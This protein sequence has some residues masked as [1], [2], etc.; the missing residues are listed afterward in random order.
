MKNRVHYLLRLLLGIRPAESF[1]DGIRRKILKVQKR[2]PH[3]QFSET[4][5]VNHLRSLGINTGDVVIVHASWRGM[6]ALES[7]PASVVEILLKTIGKTGTLVMPC[8]GSKSEKLDVK[9]TKS[10]AG[11]LSETL[12]N[13]DGAI[14]SAFPKFSMVAYGANA[15]AIISSHVNSTYQFDELSPYYISM[16]KYNAKV[17][18]IGMGEKTHKISVF[19]CASYKCKDKTDFYNNCFTKKCSGE[20]IIENEAVQFE[21]IDRADNYSNNKKVFLSLF[22]SV[23]KHIINHKGYSI[24]MFKAADAYRIAYNFCI[25]GG[26]LYTH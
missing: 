4:S 21:Y 10:T 26:E 11:V 14:R 8:Y 12:R 19:H 17:L 16:D 18:L 3:K 23:P 9:K 24:V 1:D 22:G 5:F 2:L 25:N 15:E 7:T 6:Y 20:V 13:R